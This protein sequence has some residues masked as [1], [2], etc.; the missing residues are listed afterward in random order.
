MVSTWR[1][2]LPDADQP[3]FAEGNDGGAE[4]AEPVGL[5]VNYVRTNYLLAVNTVGAEISSVPDFRDE[6]KANRRRTKYCLEHRC[7]RTL[8]VEATNERASKI[9]GRSNGA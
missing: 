2:R 5:I 8:R 3:G 6:V 7:V 1:T 9:S 4:S